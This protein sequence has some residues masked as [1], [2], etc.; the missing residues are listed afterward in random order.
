MWPLFCFG[1]QG[2]VVKKEKDLWSTDLEV[3]EAWRTLSHSQ[4]KE[5]QRVLIICIAM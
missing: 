1:V 5:I 4:T 3:E 2:Y